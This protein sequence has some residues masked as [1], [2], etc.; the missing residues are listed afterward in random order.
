MEDHEKEV[1]NRTVELDMLKERRAAVHQELT[2][3]EEKRAIEAEEY[4]DRRMRKREAGGKDVQGKHAFSA[5]QDEVEPR[6]LVEV[7]KD[8]VSVPSCTNVQA[9]QIQSVGATCQ[10]PRVCSH[11]RQKNKRCAMPCSSR[12]SAANSTSAWHHGLDVDG[13]WLAEQ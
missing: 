8:I 2:E 6:S 10:G 11:A 4:K 7:Q 13:A 3:L 1:D 5:V 12:S 9:D